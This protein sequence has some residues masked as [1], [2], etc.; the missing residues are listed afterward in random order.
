MKKFAAILGTLL[1]VLMAVSLIACEGNGNKKEDDPP[2][3]INVPTGAFADWSSEPA[4]NPMPQYA[5]L[6]TGDSGL[7]VDDGAMKIIWGADKQDVGFE[8]YANLP[9]DFDYS[10]FDGIYF[11]VKAVGEGNAN[12]Y[13]PVIR[14]TGDHAFDFGAR[15]AWVT[16]P[17]YLT[18]LIP[19]SAVTDQPWEGSAF[20]GTIQE[21]FQ[22]DIT[23]VK[24]YGICP[25]LNSGA[26]SLANTPLTVYYDDIGFYTSDATIVPGVKPA[27]EWTEE[28]ETYIV[29]DFEE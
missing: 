20:G 4:T 8:I 26:V 19:F 2:S 23:M 10:V 3:I 24:R 16:A 5:N 18:V 29:W 25:R 28:F 11:K 17:D 9:E 7:S 27:A 13:L 12:E 15:Y 21:W 6:Y 14:S 1:V 22:E